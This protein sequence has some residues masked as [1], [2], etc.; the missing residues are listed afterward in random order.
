[1]APGGKYDPAKV[2]E[3]VAAF[4]KVV[5]TDP[6]AKFTVTATFDGTRIKLAGEVSDRTHHDQ[7][8]DLLVAMRLLEITNEIRV[9]KA[10][11]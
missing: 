10:T 4:Q 5:V 9:P 7:L 11:K 8:I 6:A 1:V 3:Y 2:G